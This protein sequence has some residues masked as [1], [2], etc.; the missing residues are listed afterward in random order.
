MVVYLPRRRR[1]GGRNL[2][3]LYSS[4]AHDG[5][6]LPKCFGSNINVR[7][8]PSSSLL[9]LLRHHFF[10]SSS[11]SPFWFPS[12]CVPGLQGRASVKIELAQLGLII[13]TSKYWHIIECLI[14]FIILQS[15]WIKFLKVHNIT[16]VNILCRKEVTTIER[17]WLVKFVLQLL[18]IN[19]FPPFKLTLHQ[20]TIKYSSVQVQPYWNH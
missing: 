20:V 15:G 9:S 17:G 11:F 14:L 4:I 2:F 16:N 19:Q 10:F 12:Y 5:Y 1:G 7:Y 3:S 8:Q 6:V 13:Q 18:A